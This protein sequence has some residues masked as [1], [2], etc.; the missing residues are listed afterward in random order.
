MPT[1]EFLG[2]RIYPPPPSRSTD[3]QLTHH[4][5]DSSGVQ[6]AEVRVL[7]ERDEMCFGRFLAIEKNTE[8]KQGTAEGKSRVAV[9]VV[10]AVPLAG[11][12]GSRACCWG[13]EGDRL[14]EMDVAR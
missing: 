2:S 11:S 14:P 5:C 10:H 13:L 4:N 6:R 8:T 3:H 1:I 12:V 9:F 7:E